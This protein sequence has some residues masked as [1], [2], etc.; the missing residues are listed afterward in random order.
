[1]TS[2]LRIIYC[3]RLFLLLAFLCHAIRFSYALCRSSARS[4]SAIRRRA[5]RVLQSSMQQKTAPS[6]ADG[7]GQAMAIS[8][9]ELFVGE[10]RSI[11]APGRVLTYTWDGSGWTPDRPD[12]GD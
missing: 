6:M 9:D 5:D 8:G 1:M 4:N 12:H 7:F 11:H 3:L 2:P 10:A